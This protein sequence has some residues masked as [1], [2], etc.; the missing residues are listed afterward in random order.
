MAE[1]TLVPRVY[2]GFRGADFRGEEIN[3]VRSPD[4]L[5]VWKDYKETESIR[6]R[7]AMKQIESFNEKVYGIFFYTAGDTEI[8]LVHSGTKLYKVTGWNT[9]EIKKTEL[10]SGLNTIPSNSFVHNNIW[11]FKDGKNYLQYDG[12]TI[13]TVEGFI[14][15]TSINRTPAGSGEIHHYTNFLSDCNPI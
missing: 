1:I 9:N 3:L 5:N 6:T 14:P 15:T 12:A 2:S 8:M 4:C 7:P 11:Y 10:Y 13:K